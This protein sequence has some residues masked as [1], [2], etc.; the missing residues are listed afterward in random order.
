V[1]GGGFGGEI[2][3]IIQVDRSGDTDDS[4]KLDSLVTKSV[5]VDV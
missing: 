4:S 1:G 2:Q 3:R 5:F